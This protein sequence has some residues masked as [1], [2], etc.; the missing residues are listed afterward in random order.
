MT[1]EASCGIVALFACSL[2]WIAENR[3]GNVNVGCFTGNRL[4]M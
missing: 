3:C 4:A 2:T 1:L